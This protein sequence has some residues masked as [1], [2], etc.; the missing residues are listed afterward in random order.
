MSLE[1][2]HM[3]ELNRETS[4]TEPSPVRSRLN[5]ADATPK[6]MLS[7][8]VLSPKPGRGGA[9]GW[10][11]RVNV[12]RIPA[13]PKNTAE[14]YPGLPPSGPLEPTA[15]ALAKMILGL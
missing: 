12:L 7:D 15:S 4:T 6:A 13:R 10:P 3:A 1:A 9:N 5:R 11:V 8:A 14:S 2:T